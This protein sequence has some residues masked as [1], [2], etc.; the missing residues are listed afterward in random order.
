[1]NKKTTDA[2]GSL[3]WNMILYDEV[4]QGVVEE[5]IERTLSHNLPRVDAYSQAIEAFVRRRGPGVTTERSEI[6]ATVMGIDQDAARRAV[7]GFGDPEMLEQA[8]LFNLALY[9]LDERKV[10]DYASH[11]GYY[12][13]EA[14]T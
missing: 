11:R 4:D 3:V 5:V 13:R 1:M 8:H 14:A 2:V 10:I 9:R 12:L 7:A 6:A